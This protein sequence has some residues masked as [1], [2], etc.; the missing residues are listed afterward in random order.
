MAGQCTI[1]TVILFGSCAR[2]DATHDSDVDVC[3]FLREGRAPE[4]HE[5]RR[6]AP[7]LPDEP[8]SLVSYSEHDLAAMLS[9]GSLFLWHIKL[10]GQVLYG[11][12][13]AITLLN[14]L[15]P[16]TRH[17]EEILYHKSLLADLIAASAVVCLPNEFDLSLLFTIARNTCM[18][19]SHK[20]GIPVFSPRECYCRAAS[21]FPDMPLPEVAYSQLSGWKAVYE[22]GRAPR[23]PLPHSREMRD[24]LSMI[25]EL[26]EYADERT[27]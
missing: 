10:E 15:K 19:L 1:S 9:Y 18:I 17:H 5:L 2:G 24:L 21:V 12:E 16:F 20:E 8:L 27:R 6:L 7:S 11:H 25:S 3:A 4:Q 13:H 26:L 23:N 14:T 22:R